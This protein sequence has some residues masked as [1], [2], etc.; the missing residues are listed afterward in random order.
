MKMEGI[1][2]ATNL[3]LTGNLGDFPSISLCQ[4][5]SLEQQFLKVLQYAK[6]A[7]TQTYNH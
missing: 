2:I 3:N 4:S 6:L 7:T 1:T 5:D